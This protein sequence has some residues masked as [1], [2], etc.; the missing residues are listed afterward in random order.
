MQSVYQHEDQPADKTSHMPDDWE[1]LYNDCKEGGIWNQ[2]KVDLN[3]PVVGVDWWDAYAYAEWR[4]RRLPT[5]EEWYVACS[6]GCDPEH[7]A[8]TG[9]RPVDQT[10]KTA[11]GIYGMA[12]NVSEWIRERPWTRP[13]LRSLHA[14]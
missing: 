14:I 9:W 13:I 1:N 2:L 12:G 3:Y 8:G 7:F 6:S 10:E 5:H 4:S 11:G